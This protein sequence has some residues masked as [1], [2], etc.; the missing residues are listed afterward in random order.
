MGYAGQ[1]N[2]PKVVAAIEA[3]L[4]RIRAAGRV[5]GTLTTP[6]LLDRHLELGVQFFYVG[7]GSLLEPA[8]A[9]FVRRVH[10]R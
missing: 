6:Q 7:L 4:Q 8:S 1:T 9:D 3:A 10:S 5:S 2:H